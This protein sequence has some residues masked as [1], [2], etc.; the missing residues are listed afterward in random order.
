VAVVEQWVLVVQAAV[1]IQEKMEVLEVGVQKEAQGLLELQDKEVLAALRI[2]QL[3][4]QELEAEVQVGKEEILRVLD[5]QV[6]VV[7]E[8][9]RQFQELQ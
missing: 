5:Q 1:N 9:H 8:Q 6:L 3:V 2:S 4:K 7:Q